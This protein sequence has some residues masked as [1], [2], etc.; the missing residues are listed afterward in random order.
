MSRNAKVTIEDRRQIAAKSRQNYSFQQRKLR[1]YWTD[2][3]QIC[4][5]FIHIIAI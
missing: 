1:D 5:L 4:T 2:A 3:H